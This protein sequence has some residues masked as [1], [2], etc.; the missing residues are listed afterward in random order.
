MFIVSRKEKPSDLTQ[1]LYRRMQATSEILWEKDVSK[2]MK[3]KE[4]QSIL[5]RIKIVT[6]SFTLYTNTYA[7][8][9]S[10]RTN[11]CSCSTSLF[12]KFD[13]LHDFRD[14]K[15]I[16]NGI[17]IMCHNINIFNAIQYM[18]KEEKKYTKKR[19]KSKSF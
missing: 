3:C 17:R 6:L 10:K 19:K 8:A 2:K 1:I 9:D 11:Y 5:N 13:M 16:M 18:S 15:E 14:M 4:S 7:W 12:L